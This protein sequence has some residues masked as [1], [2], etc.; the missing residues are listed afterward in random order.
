MDA[1][2]ARIF[3][4]VVGMYFLIGIITAGFMYDWPVAF[5]TGLGV[6]GGL[7]SGLA[8]L[9]RSRSF[10]GPASRHRR[11]IG[12]IAPIGGILIVGILRFIGSSDLMF[13]VGGSVCMMMLIESARLTLFGAYQPPPADDRWFTSTQ[14]GHER[15]RREEEQ[16][17]AAQR[18]RHQR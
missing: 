18:R 12:I 4:G 13:F 11:S 8:I 6:G 14:T 1:R 15:L 10:S 3:W 5:I 9:S 16:W 2:S 7:G 17:R